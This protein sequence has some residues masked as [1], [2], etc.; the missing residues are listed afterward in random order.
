MKGVIIAAGYGTRFLPVTKVVPKELIPLVTVPSIDFIV[1][2]FARSG[3]EDI[4]IVSSRRKRS[5]EDYF[6]R[7][8]ELEGIFE[9]EGKA[10]RLASIAPR[11]GLRFAYVRQQRMMGT[12]H[13]LLQ[14]KNLL[15]GEP[16]VVA[17]P[18]DLHM[19]SV[20]LAGQ[21]IDQ[22][23]ATGCAVLA[24]LHEDGDVSRYGVLDF[25][26]D[27]KHVRGIVE[28]PA[29]GSEPSHEISIGR[30][31][32]T[33]EFFEYLEE[34]WRLHQEAQ[35]TGEYFHIYALNKLMDAGKVVSRRIEGLRLDTGD[36]EGYLEATLRYA[37]GVPSLKKVLDRYV[38]EYGSRA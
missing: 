4:I 17:Y 25:D 19:G 31:L 29:P 26:A 33:S 22:W 6:D 38:A 10:E 32:Y 11:S 5:L 24:S 13:A 35:S 21:L 30:Y 2:E 18:D 8:V 20:P 23:K 37:E 9:K 28:K 14:V 12:G 15:G 34:G 36:P 3:I 16:C 27:G 1:Q 7:E